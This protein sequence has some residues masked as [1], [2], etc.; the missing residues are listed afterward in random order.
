MEFEIILYIIYLLA[1]FLLEKIFNSKNTIGF[2]INLPN[3]FLIALIVYTVLPLYDCIINE[4][5]NQY[6]EIFLIKCLV[7]VVMLGIGFFLGKKSESRFVIAR[8]NYQAG[9]LT[10]NQQRFWTIFWAIVVFAFVGINI[11]VNRG[12]LT[13]VLNSSYR[14][15]YSGNNNNVAAL[16][17]AAM[18]YAMI[19]NDKDIITRK[20][21]RAIATILTIVI[22]GLN[23]L[24]GNRNLAIMI[25]FAFA[26]TRFKGK[27]FNKILIYGGIIIGVFALGI[28]AVMREYSIF[29]VLN[30]SSTIDWNS[31]KEYAFSFSNG[32]LGTTFMFEKYK[33]IAVSS[34]KFPYGLGYSYFVLPIL[35]L[36]PSSIWSS[37]PMAYADYFSHYGFG[38]Y[39][40]MGYGFSPIYEAEVNF[41]ALW[42]IVF[43]AIGFLLARFSKGSEKNVQ[44]FYNVG[45]ISCLV[46]NFF[47]I[48]FSTC[49]KFFVMMWVFKWIYLKSFR[50]K[51]GQ[52]Y[53]VEMGDNE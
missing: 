38:T 15:S 8:N 9:C 36:I 46:L 14:E 18:P 26:W 30:G 37:K 5:N 10:I 43:F 27:K 3:M 1:L 50:L 16:L 24:I 22:V 52:K 12:G 51:I 49:F 39:D 2:I 31:A 19:F 13:N 53:Y 47:R 41:G 45:L 32:E 23:F 7:I 40:G 44:K 35:N 34:F 28:I 25:V 17:Y 42:W 33:N 21:I 11:M 29:L 6:I 48:D 4:K 20:E